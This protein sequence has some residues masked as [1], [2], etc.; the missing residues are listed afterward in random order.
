M[1]VFLCMCP[2]LPESRLMLFTVSL[3]LAEH[4]LISRLLAVNTHAADGQHTRLYCPLQSSEEGRK[5]SLI[6]LSG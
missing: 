3:K 2:A 1:P 4:M 5:H 6:W